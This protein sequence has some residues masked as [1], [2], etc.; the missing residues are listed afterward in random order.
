MSIAQGDDSY[1][2]VALD[3]GWAFP[4][5]GEARSHLYVGSNGYITFISGD[6]SYS[7]S[8]WRHFSAPR[9][10]VFFDD[11]RPAHYYTV[12]Y[13]L[14]TE[15][16]VITWDAIPEFYRTG[17]NTMQATLYRDG[18]IKLAYLDLTAM[19]GIV[20]LSAGRGYAGV[21]QTDFSE[22]Y[23]CGGDE[24]GHDEAV[25]LSAGELSPVCGPSSG[26][27]LVKV[28]GTFRNECD[29]MRTAGAMPT[30]SNTTPPPLTHLT[31]A[32]RT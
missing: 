1:S 17:A 7:E 10:S 21:A 3:A 22:I 32:Q 15:R 6:R 25:V 28:D 8:F 29:T 31:Q 5:F 16:I 18:S 27:T 4:F 23:S 2:Y 26:G 24:V 19:D 13:R 11:L 20:G 30:S 14:Y 12:S 9:I